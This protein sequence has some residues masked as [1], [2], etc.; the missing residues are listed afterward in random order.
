M[1]TYLHFA[2][3]E[4]MLNCKNQCGVQKPPVKTGRNRKAL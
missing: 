1:S 3:G 2:S 4:T